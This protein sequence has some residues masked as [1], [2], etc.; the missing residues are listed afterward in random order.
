MCLADINSSDFRENSI[1]IRQ[2]PLRLL[3][4]MNDCYEATVG[5][6]SL[7]K[8][9]PCRWNPM[10]VT[11]VSRDHLLAIIDINGVASS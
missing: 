1:G 9:P 5:E 11:G 8:V 7:D 4:V 3:R 6:I 2:S 10:G